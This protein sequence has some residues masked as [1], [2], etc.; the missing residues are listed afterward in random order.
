MVCGPVCGTSR[1]REVEEDEEEEGWKPKLRTPGR[2]P[3]PHQCS[4]LWVWVA[5]S[6]SK[7]PYDNALATLAQASACSGN[8]L[9]E[10]EASPGFCATRVLQGPGPGSSTGRGQS[11]SPQGRPAPGARRRHLQTRWALAGLW[12]KQRERLPSPLLYTQAWVTPTHCRFGVSFKALRLGGP[13]RAEPVSPCQTRLQP[14]PR[15]EPM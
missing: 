6:F 3:F 7:V 8:G 9:G 13:W 14:Q 2:Q 5:V 10:G 1:R 11:A 15:T 4:L 12:R